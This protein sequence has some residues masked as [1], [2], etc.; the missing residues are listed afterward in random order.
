V[1]TVGAKFCRRLGTSVA[2]T[3]T[4]CAA[5]VLPARAQTATLP[6]EIRAKVDQ[7]AQQVLKDTGVPSASV[8]IVVRGKIVYVHAYGNARLNPPV[9]ARTE[10]AYSIGS[11]SKQFTSTAI[12]MLLEQGKLSLDD[13]VSKFIPNLTR[14]NEVTVR[15]LL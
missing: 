4:I 1:T 5:F 9:A 12:L 7:V 15:Q 2:A 13:T 11:V 14:A 6:A 10:M 3:V 8:A